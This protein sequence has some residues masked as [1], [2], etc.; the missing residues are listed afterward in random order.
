MT[1][2]ELIEKLK[3]FDPEYEVRTEGC[4]CYGDV[5]YVVEIEYGGGK[6]AGIMRTDGDY[7]RDEIEDD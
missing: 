3:T 5:G 4:D 1:V 6:V 2:K 7:F